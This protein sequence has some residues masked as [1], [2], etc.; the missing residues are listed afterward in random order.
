MIA[1]EAILFQHVQR[2]PLATVKGTAP[3]RGDAHHA[4]V[5]PQI[6][7]VPHAPAF[8]AHLLG[9]LAAAGLKVFDQIKERGVQFR[10]VGRFGRPVTHLDIDIQMKIR[11]PGRF[12][13]RVPDA[14]QVHRQCAGPAA[15][16]Q[17]I[18]AE[19]EVGFHQVRVI[20]LALA[21]P[22]DPLGR[23]EGCNFRCRLS[24][25]NRQAVE[26]F[27]VIR[28][29]TAAKRLLIAGGGS[30]ECVGCPL[31]PAVRQRRIAVGLIEVGG[32]G[33]QDGRFGRVFQ[34]QRIGRGR[35]RAIV[36]GNPH[37]A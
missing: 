34:F 10:E 33:N 35:E 7:G 16:D 9:H 28:D 11:T 14:L 31:L 18:A 21:E 5:G 30:V 23:G 22:L 13:V 15:G 20:A 36:L 12:K 26:I 17:Q 3:E 25:F 24:E 37:L 1:G 32:S 19:L 4:G 6:A 27:S 8:K 2:E 29:R